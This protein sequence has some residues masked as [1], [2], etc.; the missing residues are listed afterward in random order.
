MNTE[1]EI[2]PPVDRKGRS[3]GSQEISS[4]NRGAQLSARQAIT[5][6]RL[7]WQILSDD[8]PH[9]REIVEFEEHCIDVNLIKTW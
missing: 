4:A 5:S 3:G 2:T 1:K 7:R 8:A 9:G 6:C